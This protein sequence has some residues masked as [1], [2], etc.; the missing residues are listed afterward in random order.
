MNIKKRQKTYS[1]LFFNVY[2]NYALLLIVFAILLGFIYIKLYQNETVRDYKQQLTDEAENLSKRLS[3]LIWIEDYESCKADLE[4]YGT[5]KPQGDI[6]TISNPNANNPMSAA[7]VTVDLEGE[8]IADEV[9][10]IIDAAFTG[11]N[12]SETY[13]SEIHGASTMISVGVPIFGRNNEVVGAL[14]LNVPLE[15]QDKMT[16]RGLSTIIISSIVAAG[17]SIIIAIIFVRNLTRPIMR[18]RDTALKLADGQYETK[19]GINR[20]DEIGDLAKTIDFLTEKLQE[21]EK[22]RNNLEQMRSD[23]FANV[24][25]E[26][27]TPITVVRAYTESLVDGVVTDTEKTYQYYVR[28]LAECNSMERLVSDLLLLSKMQ[29]PDFVIEREPINIMQIFEEIVRSVRAISDEKYIYVD[30]DKDRDVYMMFGDYDRMRQMFLVILD[31]AFKFSPNN[32]TIYITLTQTDKIY[33]SIRDEGIGISEEEL[34]CIFDKFYKSKLR[35]NAKGSG[36]G[37]SIARQIALK[38]G[39]TIDVKSKISVG[40]EFLFSFNFIDDNNLKNI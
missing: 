3:P 31:N 35:Q 20:K 25:H 28:M 16:D 5:I 21:N 4:M 34:T 11:E 29:N 23:F 19:T 22:V 26:L 13:Y 6:W 36:L 39:G 10:S 1:R 18:M 40:T 24:S 38:H 17:I 14:L 8:L 30:I 2:L 32:S 33:I 27:R 15:A 7:A 37:L 12:S 9:Y